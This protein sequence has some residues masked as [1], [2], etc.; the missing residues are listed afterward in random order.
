[1]R[2]TIVLLVLLAVAQGV[3]AQGDGSRVD[4]DLGGIPVHVLMRGDDVHVAASWQASAEYS[5]FMRSYLFCGEDSC[6][7]ASQVTT[8]AN[9]SLVEG[10]WRFEE[11]LRVPT[12]APKGELRW[13]IWS[14]SSAMLVANGSID[15][16]PTIYIATEQWQT[17][18]EDFT[19]AVE[20]AEPP[21]MLLL[22]AGAAILV[23]VAL[24]AYGLMR[25]AGEHHE[26]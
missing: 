24:V 10:V 23:V 6:E 17:S 16:D 3:T 22:V 15:V 20:S 12:T 2:M 26:E 21:W 7:G 9:A 13:M 5:E 14:E 8:R 25:I 19:R 1:M 4:F 11:V 18:M